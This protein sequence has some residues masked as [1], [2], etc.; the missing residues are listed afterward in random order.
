MIHMAMLILCAKTL[1]S[2]NTLFI[3]TS[4]CCTMHTLLII[5]YYYIL[6]YLLFSE[7]FDLCCELIRFCE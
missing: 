7:Q 5:F 3:A 2:Y 1:A 6:H 4:P